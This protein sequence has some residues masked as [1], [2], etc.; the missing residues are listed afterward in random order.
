MNKEEMIEKILDR[1]TQMDYTAEHKK[2]AKDYIIPYNDA[3]VWVLDVCLG[4]KMPTGTISP[5]SQSSG[6]TAK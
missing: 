1:M 4:F 3:L 6:E 5:I 2:I